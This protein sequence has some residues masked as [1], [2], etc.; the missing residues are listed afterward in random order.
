MSG[1]NH[2]SGCSKISDVAVGCG[3]SLQPSLPLTATHCHYH[4]PSPTIQQ[5]IGQHRHNNAEMLSDDRHLEKAAVVGPTTITNTITA[6]HCHHHC[7]HHCRSLPLP[8]QPPLPLTT[9]ISFT[10]T[11]IIATI[12]CNLSCPHLSKPGPDLSQPS[13]FLPNAPTPF[14]APN[15]ATH[16]SWWSGKW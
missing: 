1:S 7:H 15:G 6:T 13:H 3:K 11:T 9:T 5:V 16:S 12:T 8:L 14:D 2:A 10:S 4:L